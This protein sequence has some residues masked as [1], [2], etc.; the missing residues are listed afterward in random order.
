M[1][2][3]I[4]YLSEY[5][6]RS[7]DD[8]A[9]NEVDGLVLAQFSYFR[10]DRI[11]PGFLEDEDGVSMTEMAQS[12]DADY[13]YKKEL[14]PEDNEKLFYAMLNSKR[15]GDMRCNF[16]SDETSEDTQMQFAAF[17]CFPNG[18]LPVIV[19]RGTD[20]TVVGW[21]EDF[22]MAFSRPYAGQRLASL[23]VNQAALRIHGDF[24]LAGHSKGGNLAAFSAMNA[25]T[26]I[27]ERIR[28]IYC[29]DSPGFRK[30]ILSEYGY[31]A[32]ASRIRKFM[33]Q[34]SIV[35]ILLEGAKDYVTV[36]SSAIGGAFQHN[37]YSWSVADTYF[38]YVDE[39]KKTSKIMKKSMN[40]W[41]MELEEP[42]LEMFVDTLFDLIS[43][44][45]AKN[46]PQIM[47]D[48]KAWFVAVRKATAD[49]DDEQRKNFRYIM[50][51]LFNAIYRNR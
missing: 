51:E 48:K 16:Y 31:D 42:D 49:L 23:Y 50:K 26:G 43:A 36:K 32:I 41:V 39:I 3:I 19:F 22:N 20:G 12:M 17:T 29:Y 30:E 8:L 11:I 21:R 44:S 33:P 9:F 2:N 4:D 35:G 13:V 24:I 45:G 46:V 6:E 1:K 34:S 47:E 25:V 38:E 5:G 15:F 28:N 40:E 18:A 37:P 27:R 14:Y 10:W 7:F